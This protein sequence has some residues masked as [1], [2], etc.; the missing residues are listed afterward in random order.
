MTTYLD[1]T[2]AYIAA[3]LRGATGLPLFAEAGASAGL[4]EDEG[5]GART[6]SLAR[7]PTVTVEVA[8]TAPGTETYRYPKPVAQMPGPSTHARAEAKVKADRS[9]TGR[10]GKILAAL[11]AYGPQT[12]L[13]L[14]H[15]TGLAENSVNSA[16]NA[17]LKDGKVHLLP[18]LDL[19]TG[20]SIVALTEEAL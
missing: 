1:E 17:L 2:E 8:A 18:G 10:R 16:T 11:T 20:R 12:R 6:V 9:L 13:A 4:D 7:K 5:E 15:A 19:A 14:M 3:R